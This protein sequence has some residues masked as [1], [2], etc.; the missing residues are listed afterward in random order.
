M[1]IMGGPVKLNLTPP[2]SDLRNTVG[3]EKEQ[4]LK[5][6]DRLASDATYREYCDKNYHQLLP[7]IAKKVHNEKMQQEK[8][9][10]VKARLNFEGCFG[11]KLKDLR[12]ITT[13]RVKDSGRKRSQEEASELPS[14][15]EVYQGS[16]RDLPH[17]A[18]R[19]GIYKRFRVRFK[20][21]S[22]HVKGASECMRISGFMHEITNPK[23]I[24]HLHDNIL[25]SVH[26][27]IRVTTGFLRGEV[28][29]SKQR[30]ER[31]RDKFTL[32]TKS[33]KEI[34]ALDKEKFKTPPP[35]TTPVEKRNINK[36]C[37]FHGKVGH[38]TDECMHLKRKVEELIKNGK[39]SHVIKEPKQVRSP[40][41]YNGII[42]RPGLRKIQ[43]VPSIAHGMLKF[44]VPG[45]ILTLRSSK[46]MPLECTMVSRPEAWPF[47]IIQAAEERIKVAIHPEHPERSLDVL[48]WKPTDM[49]GVPRHIAEHILNVR[50]G[51]SP[52]RQKKRSKAPKRNKAIQEE[53][54]RMCVDFKDL[55]KACPKDGYPLLEIDWKVES[56]CGYPFK[57]FLDAYKGY[58]QIK[59]AKEDEKKTTFITSQGVFYYSK[60]TFGLKNAE[61]TYHRLVDK[62][63]QKQIGRNLE[64]Y[65]DD[66]VIK[67]R[68]EHEIIRDIEETFKTLREINMKLNP[69]KCAFGI[70]EGTFLG[71]KVNTD[72]I[73][74]VKAEA[75]F[76]EMKKVI[77][78]LPTLIAPIEKE[79]LIV[80]LAAAQEAILAD[81]IVERLEDDSLDTPME[82]EEE[83]LDPWTLFTDG[84]SCIDGSGAGL[85]FKNAEGAEFT[86]ALR[87]RFD[88]TNNEVEYE[89]L[90]VV[91][92]ITEQ[93]GVKNL[94]E[95]IDSRLV[96]N[97]VNG[98]Y[99]AKEPGMIQYLE[100]VKVL[101]S[102]FKKFSIKQVP[103]SENKKTNALSKIAST[104]FAHLTKQVL[105]KELKEKSINE[106]KVLTIMEEEGDTWMTPIYNYLTKETRPAEKEMARLVR[107]KSGSMHAKTRYVVEKTIRTG[108]YWL[109]MHADARKLIRACQDG[110]VKKFVWDNI[111]CRFGLLREIISNNEK[112]FK[113][114]PFK[115]WCEKLCIRQCFASVKHPQ[116]NGLVERVNRILGEGIKA[117]LDKRSKDWIEE[118]PHVL[119]A[120]RIMIKSSNEDTP[121]SLT[122]ETKVKGEQAAIRE[123][124]SKAKMEKYYNSK[125]RNT[126]FK[127]GDLVYRS[128]EASHAKKSGKLSPKWEGP[129]E[130]TEALGNGVYKLR[131]HNGKLLPRT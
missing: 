110:Q 6:P 101:S 86:Y 111:V 11:K 72:G 25:K 90:I 71:Y 54:W 31:R 118:L 42:G 51:C 114:N 69:K 23:L 105:V 40:S 45:G 30:P 98:S 89:A 43:A 61:A 70:E 15:K 18:E 16:G 33:P 62:P 4:T 77:V 84:S 83:L 22:R 59:K 91:L 108:Y 122:Y 106:A 2:T 7:I 68:T 21:K 131:D 56:L 38:N 49:T 60:I 19:R 24:K 87:F 78:K 75:A 121:F 9:K 57:C 130:V 93:M 97:Q 10:E 128:N 96:A 32:L 127:P 58:H 12:S 67:S 8:L 92:R 53:I 94:Q 5:N 104:S 55:N 28:V 79:E 95:N 29:A 116:A 27:I 13:L 37:E 39:L 99:I 129:D 125:V 26:E 123:A 41:P 52:V 46:I 74:T 103:R 64:E 1:L 17:Q 85:I 20:A 82:T 115:D 50:E 36:F 102:S 48:A 119:W 76:K 120:H 3:K 113:D 14:I 65:V 44:P 109:T 47:D 107:C 73:M 35:M 34:L 117:R 124:K 112:Q 100:K 66:L 63:F 81:F 126:S 80:Y 88:A